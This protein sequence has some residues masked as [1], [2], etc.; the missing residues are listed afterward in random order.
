MPRT[1]L[2]LIWST[3]G[4]HQL[5]L[6]VLSVAV[7]LLTTVPLEMQRRI[8]DEVTAGHRYGR[9]AA[10]CAVYA[11]AALTMGGIKFG[12]NVYRGYVCETATRR[13][14]A[15]IHAAWGRAAPSSPRAGAAGPEIT[16]IVA[17]AEAVGGFAGVALSEP[18]LQGGVLLS[19]FGY[20]LVVEPW[21]AMVSLGLF[22]PQTILVPLLQAAINRRMSQRILALRGL[23][24]EL[25]RGPTA[26][27]A[28]AGRFERRIAHVFNLNMR[29]F[30]WKFGMNFLMNGLY[31]VAIVGTLAAG[32][33]LA[34]RGE[35]QV[36][37][38]V[39]FM[40]GLAQV[41]DPWGDL[42]NYFR[43]L[44]ST[45]V[46]YRLIADTISAAS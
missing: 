35:T 11:A 37:T 9:I 36:G 5:A 23:S 6:A 26:S 2:G 1:L 28:A 41:N 14:R 13:L 21:L 40:S 15:T 32:A 12:L 4:R 22:I 7:F 33:W 46:R 20:M 39:A 8:V 31:H 17:E 16:M 25:S 10:L 34:L 43:E 42:V 30:V 38:V 29:I 18:L 27:A 19:V 3:G 44:T 45:R 24:A